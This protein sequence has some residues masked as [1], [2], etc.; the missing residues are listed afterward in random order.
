MKS[1]AKNLYNQD[2]HKKILCVSNNFNI[3]NKGEIPRLFDKPFSSLAKSGAQ[4]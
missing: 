4:I 3:A 1:I 2:N